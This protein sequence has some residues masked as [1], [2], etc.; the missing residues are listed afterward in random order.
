MALGVG[1]GSLAIY[2]RAELV[3]FE[4]GKWMMERRERLREKFFV[5]EWARWRKRGSGVA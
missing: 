3:F 4:Y 2:H 5:R 1:L